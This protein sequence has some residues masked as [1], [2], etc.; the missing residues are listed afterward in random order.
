[1]KLSFVTVRVADLDSTIEF[2]KSAFGFEVKRRFSV[3]P[4]TELAFMADEDGREI[5]FIADG[6]GR[7][8]GAGLSIGFRVDDLAEVRARAT[9]LGA[10]VVME[11]TALPSGV[12][13]MRALDPNG[14]EL[15]FVKEQAR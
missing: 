4:Q 13:L 2:W 11:P 3:P 10:R 8:T 15:I 1:V 9:S 5:E 12:T 7:F 6:H 14:L